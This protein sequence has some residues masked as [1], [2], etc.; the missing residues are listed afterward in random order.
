MDLVSDQVSFAD[1]D[2][3][4]PDPMQDVLYGKFIISVAIDI[5]LAVWQFNPFL[6]DTPFH[7]LSLVG[8]DSCL[9]DDLTL[10]A[11][12]NPAQFESI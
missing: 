8:V 9:H 6:S 11:T 4:I 10:H 5:C 1:L 7:F 2:V 3:W 12:L